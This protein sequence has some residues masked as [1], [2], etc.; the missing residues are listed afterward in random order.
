MATACIRIIFAILEFPYTYISITC[1]EHMKYSTIT[2]HVNMLNMLH[3][4]EHIAHLCVMHC[5]KKK[6]I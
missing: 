1:V 4:F 6:V 2:H 5:V 3:D